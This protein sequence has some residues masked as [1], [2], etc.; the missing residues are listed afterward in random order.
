MTKQEFI[1]LDEL[2]QEKMVKSYFEDT[3]E[4]RIEVFGGRIFIID[5]ETKFQFNTNIQ[6]FLDDFEKTM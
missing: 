3:E 6:V 5:E 4:C 2:E 1:N